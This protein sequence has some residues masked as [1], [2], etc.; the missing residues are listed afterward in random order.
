MKS[1]LL[2]IFTAVLL[3]FNTGTSFKKEQLK[4]PRVQTAYK[5][6]W[7]AIKTKLQKAGI[8]SSHFEI[9][10]MVFKHEGQLQ[11]W[12]RSKSATPFKLV[13]TYSICSSS[14]TLGPKRRE[15]DGQV[16][17]GF[18]HVSAFQA[19]SEFYLALQVNYPNAADRINGDK[20]HPGGDIMIHGNC[21]TIGCMPMTDEIIKEIYLMAVEAR[22]DG[23]QNIP[24]CIFPTKLTDSGM[25]WLKDNVK[26]TEKISFWE[27][28]KTGYDYFD[29]KKML[30]TIGV[31]AK[32]NYTF[33]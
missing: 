28:L 23:E 12:G 27:N 5:E 4:Y 13:D 3:S 15:G 16:P 25:A 17:E 31:N 18:Y 22:N 14:G 33:N 29:S 10:I 7:G 26:D 1:I 20:N 32:G 24:I 21:V 8:D 6:K 30:P 9:C 19:M 2:V 11:V